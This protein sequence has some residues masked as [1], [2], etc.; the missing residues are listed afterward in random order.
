MKPILFALATYGIA[1]VIAACVAV[2]IKFIALVVQR[3]DKSDKATGA[4]QES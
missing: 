2:I 1:I 4:K 3:R